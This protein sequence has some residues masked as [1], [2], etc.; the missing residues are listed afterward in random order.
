L[1]PNRVIL[2][3]YLCTMS[4]ISQ[5]PID[6]NVEGNDKWIGTSVNNANAT[7]NFSVDLVAEYLN[8]VSAIQ[9]QELRYTYQN[10]Q[11]VDTRLA[12]TISFDPSLT[13]NVPFSGITG[14]RISAFAKQLKDVQT[15][16]DAPLV[17]STILITN[18]FNPSNWAIFRWVSATVNIDDANFYDI[19]LTHIDSSGE[20]VATQDYLVSLLDYGSA[21]GTAW[22]AITGTLSNQADLQAALDAKVA[23]NAAIVGGQKTK[24]TYDVKGLVT[25]GDDATTADIADSL[26]KR[27]V[28]DANLVVI[29]NTSGTNS[30]DNAINSLYSGLAASK[31]DTLVSGTNIKTINGVSVLGSGNIVI[32]SGVAWGAITGTLSAQADLQSALDAKLTKNVAITGDTAT[33]ITYDINGLITGS[34][35]A[36]TADIA[37]SL[38]LRYVTDANLV[39][40][41]NTSGTNTGD[42]V[43]GA[44]IKT[45]NGNSLLGAGDVAVQ[46]TLVSATNIKTINGVTILG[47]GDLAVTASPSGIAGAIQFSDGSAFASDAAELF[48]DNTNKRLGIGIN[49]PL[50]PLH[51]N[52]TGTTSATSSF[53]TF[54]SAGSNGLEVR[55]DG[56]V[57]FT[58]A[59]STQSVQSAYGSFYE[60]R[61]PNSG[62]GYHIGNGTLKDGNNNLAVQFLST[63][64]WT[65]R[66][67]KINEGNVASTA[68]ASALLELESTIKGFLPP[69]MTT[70]QRV[71]ITTP[72][73]GLVVHDTDVDSLYLKKVAGWTS[74]QSAAP[75]VG[76]T[77]S[78]AT[79]TINTDLV[80]FYSLTAQAADITSFTTNLSGT[81]TEG[82]VLRIAITGTAA[83][84]ITW[85]TSF[86]NG[87]ATLPTTTVTTARLDVT[88]FWNSVTSKW[89]CMAQG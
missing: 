11:G 39:V 34:A 35:A 42:L 51:I 70:A 85:G 29:G 8:T 19:V 67:A 45:V 46:A 57:I 58:Q 63:R 77:T 84:A 9:S 78:S 40:I 54:N 41:G 25:A 48:W 89:R 86:E 88:F 24:I 73:T 66:P 75:R 5:Y 22:G 76:T 36:T 32:T 3:Y 50:S 44:T 83:R 49:L 55:D 2:I 37:D 82:Q 27:Y 28:T 18:A 87:A 62:G 38:N 64:F 4:R 56:V 61:S 60:L 1:F 80:D 14:W 30:G 31:Q 21:S 65:G 59:G 52:G 74:L 6:T 17:G 33:K 20:L 13:D 7:K 68:V 15:F 16:Y 26:D 12:G 72:A 71:A 47:A 23:A 10:V 81:P 79:P 69:R 43:S 53:K